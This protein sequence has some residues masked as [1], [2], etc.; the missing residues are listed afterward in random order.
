[1]LSVD[2]E[3]GRHMGHSQWFDLYSK[4]PVCMQNAA[5]SLAG[6]NM[7]RDRYNNT[8]H[9]AL[10]FLRQ[11]QWWS[12]AGQQAYQN[13]QL[14]LVIEHAYQT[15]PYYRE[16]FDAR[17]LSPRDI[18]TTE[19]L[20]KLPVL[21]KST[22]RKRFRDLHSKGWPQKRIR[23]GHTGGTTGTSLQLISDMDTQPWQWAVWWRHRERFGLKLHDPFIVFAGRDVV[24]LTSMDPPVW[25]RNL[26]MRQTYMS[27]HHLTE[28]NMP[29]VANYLCSRKVNYYSGYPSAIYLLARYFLDR[30][31]R[32]PH[33]P[34]VVVTGAE[35]LLPHQQAVIS[36]AFETDVAD[37]YGASEQCGN[38]SECERHIYHVDMEFGVVE[39]LP[40]AGMPDNM[41][42]IVCTGFHNFA[43]P[44]I[45]YDIGDIATLSGKP[46]S[47][48]RQSPAVEKIDGRIESYIITPDGRQLG[49]L[50]FLFKDSAKIEEA[51]LVQDNINSVTVKIVRSPGYD[52]TDERSLDN[53]MHR[54]LG[55][56]INIKFEYLSAIPRETNGKFRQI[57]SHILPHGDEN[58]RNTL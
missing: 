21:E 3:G 56:K 33:P 44:L 37:Q 54:Y 2:T 29:P 14:R 52:S 19:D 12:L 27:V 9:N 7:R 39:F 40:L 15:V 51:Q 58:R 50:D 16:I 6:V 55:D 41:R 23:H 34:H 4:M 30:R 22:I 26:P 20:H 32:L 35:T 53:E 48:G 25:R 24:P 5:C 18:R 36:R 28:K 45:R 47:C 43:M 38:I 31:I 8:F 1:M 13:E 17:K 46:C 42:R 57:V 11:S 10:E 49:R